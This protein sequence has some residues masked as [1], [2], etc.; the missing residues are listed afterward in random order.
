MGEELC[1][2]IDP[3]LVTF[4][5]PMS[6]LGAPTSVDAY[7]C[8]RNMA[9]HKEDDDDEE[10]EEVCAVCLDKL[11]DNTLSNSSEEMNEVRQLLHSCRHSFHK[12]CLLALVAQGH[13]SC[14]LCRANFSAV[15]QT[16]AHHKFGPNEPRPANWDPWRLE[17][18]IY[19][20]GEDVLF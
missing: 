14:P 12:V 15:N 5:I 7:S 1:G 9:N 10:K 4:P 3:S 2:N 20:F 18:M 8:P 11:Y 17:R 13:H 19:L 16:A 6:R